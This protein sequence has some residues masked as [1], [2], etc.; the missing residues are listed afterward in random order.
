MFSTFQKYWHFL[1]SLKLCIYPELQIFTHAISFSQKAFLHNLQYSL[2]FI[3]VFL[4]FPF[5]SSLSVPPILP[6]TPRALLIPLQP[7][8][9]NSSFSPSSF[10]NSTPKTNQFNLLHTLSTRFSSFL[11]LHPLFNYVFNFLD[12]LI[13][14]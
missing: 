1:Q 7:L 10:L 6:N 11:A 13:N 9:I 8:K 5:L 14:F 4:P 2:L 12:N 3:P